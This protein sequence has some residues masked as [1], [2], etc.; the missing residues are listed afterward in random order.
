MGW[1]R[2]ARPPPPHP[3]LTSNRQVNGGEPICLC[4]GVCGGGG[5]GGGGGWRRLA[6]AAVAAAAV[7]V[8]AVAVAVAAVAVAAVA[9]AVARW[10]WRRGLQAGENE[11]SQKRAASTRTA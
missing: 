3:H 9:M 6:V 7:A 4:G 2:C 1:M 5:V 10:Q 11:T 8:A